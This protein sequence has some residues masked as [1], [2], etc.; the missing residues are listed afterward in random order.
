[1]A[2][3]DEIIY[4]SL[5]IDDT[6]YKTLL[7]PKFLTKKKFEMRD[8]SKLTAFIPGTIRSLSTEEGKTVAEGELLCTLEAMKMVN[9]IVAPYDAVVAKIYV[10]EGVKV[11]KNQVLIELKKPGS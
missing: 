11:T 7:P 3:K 10:E 6:A 8:N 2:N 9:R 5:T 4:D 1:M